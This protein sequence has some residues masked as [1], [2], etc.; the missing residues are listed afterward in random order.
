M[1]PE[2]TFWEDRI[3]KGHLCAVTFSA[4]EQGYFTGKIAREILVNNKEPLCFP[5]EVIKKG[6]PM[7]SLAR[8]NKLGL[9]IKSDLLLS[10]EVINKFEWEE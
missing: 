10:V 6:E 8:A 2:F 5:F 7:I 3:Y 9:K 1:I 4:Y